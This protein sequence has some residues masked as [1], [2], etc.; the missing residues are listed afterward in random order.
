MCIMQRMRKRQRLNLYIDRE[1]YE[2]AR[3]ALE[4]V[5]S[6]VSEYVDHCLQKDIDL[7]ELAGQSRDPKIFA[8]GVERSVLDVLAHELADLSQV[9]R[10]VSEERGGKEKVE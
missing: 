8:E 1:L 9:M 7:L 4:S 10:T 3:D 6:S 5:G 2:R